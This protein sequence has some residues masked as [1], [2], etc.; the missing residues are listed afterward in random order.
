MWWGFEA[1]YL[2]FDELFTGKHRSWTRLI[3]VVAAQILI[4]FLVWY[5]F[6]R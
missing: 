4:G 3:L 6:F 2:F 5:F 1:V